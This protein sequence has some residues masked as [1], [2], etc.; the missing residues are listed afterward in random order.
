MAKGKILKNKPLAVVGNQRR[1]DEEE[2]AVGW[3]REEE[4]REEG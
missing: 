2:E 3:G 4:K 1:A